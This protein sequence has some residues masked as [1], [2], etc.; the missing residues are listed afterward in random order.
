MLSA[1]ALRHELETADK[2]GG[3]ESLFYLAKNILG[4]RELVHNP[5]QQVCK[6]AEDVVFKDLNGLDLEPRGSFK[7]TVFSQALPIWLLIRNPDLRILLDSAVLQNSIDNLRVVKQHF[8]GG[9]K[10]RYLF[11]NFVGEYWTTEEITV[12]TRKRRDLKEPSVRCAS[13]ERVQVGPHYDVIIADDLVSDENSKTPDGREKVKTHLKLLLSLL[14]P[15][16]V[17]IL[18]GTRWHYE[19]LYG[20]ILIEFPQFARRVRSAVNTDGTLY[21]KERLTKNALDAIQKIQGRDIFSCQ[22]LNDPS[23]EDADAKFQRSHF[24]GYAKLPDG[25]LPA[26]RHSFVTIDP[27]GEKKGSDE[28]VLMGAHVDE[29]NN[30]L[31]DRLRKGNWKPSQ[32]WDQLYGMIDDLEAAGGNVLCIG[33]ETTGGQHWL[34]DMLTDE[35]RKRSRYYPVKALP[36]A[37]DSKEYRIMRLQPQYQCGAVYHSA[38]MGPLEEQLVRFPKGKDDVADAAAMILEIGY[39]PRRNRKADTTP[40]TFDEY[41]LRLAKPGQTRRHVHSILGSQY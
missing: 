39:P 26:N 21:F 8:E 30:K 2:V 31:Y 12:R 14:E 18:V 41:V 29:E 17:L 36:H 16:G 35:M 5:H 4:Y 25:K 3:R 13:V 37:G 20:M 27:G 33:L 7:T 1:D 22:Y 9:E 23:P 40:K 11:G 24:K 38:E 32:V 6:F 10:L 19:D 28:W 15:N 34:Y